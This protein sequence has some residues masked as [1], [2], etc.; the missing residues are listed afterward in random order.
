MYIDFYK[1]NYDILSETEREEYEQRDKE[2]Y[3]VV[4]EEWFHKNKLEFVERRW[5]IKEI[6]YLKKI[7]DFITLIREAERLY[8][9]GF[10]TSCIA[11]V[12]VSSEDFSKYLSLENNKNHHI[13]KISNR[14]RTLDVSQ[15]E[16]LTL[17]LNEGLIDQPS[18]DLFDDIRK[19]RNDC[20]HYNNQFKQ[21]NQS[22]LKSDAIAALN[23][24]KNLLKNIIGDSLDSDDYFQIIDELVNTIER[25]GFEKV[26]WKQKNM[27]SH[28]FN[29]NITQ[30][31]NIKKIN[32]SSIFK[33]LNVDDEEID[34]LD[35]SAGLPV[36]V[37]LDDS[38]KKL[39]KN[40]NI[41]KGDTI[42]ASVRSHVAYD[43]Q[44]RAFILESAIK[45]HI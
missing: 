8:E 5:D 29:E 15:S 36:I 12:G 14:G 9:L 22:Q 19:I 6:H 24:L 31:P 41:K 10:Y 28:F 2:A 35:Q 44:T 20:L 27:F 42:I 33:V 18:F 37:D 34:L 32:K 13:S 1:F 17:Q 38:S 16:R 40:A 23:N 3:L 21:K 26:A 25:D 4:L 30:D 43:G 39:L 7:G 11:L 45:I